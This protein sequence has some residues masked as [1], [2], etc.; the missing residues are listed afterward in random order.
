LWTEE[1]LVRKWHVNAARTVLAGGA[2]VFCG[3]L[4]PFLSSSQPDLYQV[5]AAP[6]DT[7]TFFGI[8]LA[9]IGVVIMLVK[10][11]R[12]KMISAIV[13]LIVAGLTELTMLGITVTGLA[14]F[15]QSDGFGGTLHV[16][17]SPHVGIFTA[18]IGCAVAG[19]G[20]VISF[21]RR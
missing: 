8:V 12:A 21:R 10:S 6:Q 9:A 7:A 3:S 13:T 4:L 14:G 19:T 1:N 18:I 2:L 5:N 15:D 20:A 11:Q 17:L 16:N